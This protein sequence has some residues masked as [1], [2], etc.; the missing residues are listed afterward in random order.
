MSQTVDRFVKTTF[1]NA[2]PYN[3][4]HHDFAWQHR[5]LARMMSNECPIPPSEGVRAAVREA[6]DVGHLYPYSGKDLVAALAEYNSVPPESIVLGNGSTEVLDVLVRLLVGPGDETII[7]TPTYAFFE[8]QTRIYG[9]APKA[10]PLTSS[11]DLDVEAMLSA[12]TERTKAIFLCSPNNPTGKGWRRDQL[13][14]L[15]DTGIPVVV[16]QAYLECGYAESF[17]PLVSCHPNLVIARTMS[18]GFGLAALRVGYLI[19]DPELIDI[20]QRV[21]IPFSISLMAIWGCLQALAEPE[22]LRRRREFISS[23]AD[24]LHAAMQQMEGVKSYPS[25]G[26]FVLADISA[27]GRSVSDVVDALLAEDILIR[28]MGA[29]G[30]KGSHVRVTVG[31]TEQNDRFLKLFEELL[32]PPAMPRLS[33]RGE[34]RLT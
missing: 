3:A 14:R 30:L 16:D 33:H 23:E 31:T 32:L 34:G 9:G 1:R 6:F 24:R 17:A 7:A 20:V 25:D 11:W 28:A 29:H 26:N 8:S 15:L 13:V 18:K 5:Q 4:E 22:E 2:A 19:G 27:S 10:V 12:I 21:R